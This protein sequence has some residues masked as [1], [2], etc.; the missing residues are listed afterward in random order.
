MIV[1]L[2]YILR[3]A[4]RDRL[5]FGKAQEERFLFELKSGEIAELV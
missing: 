3:F 5:A 4:R 1:V 2:K